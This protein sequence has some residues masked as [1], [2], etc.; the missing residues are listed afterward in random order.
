MSEVRGGPADHAALDR[1]ISCRRRRQA[2]NNGSDSIR[3]PDDRPLHG[4][5][6]YPSQ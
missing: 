6:L 1:C 3:I 4:E 2:T 5:I